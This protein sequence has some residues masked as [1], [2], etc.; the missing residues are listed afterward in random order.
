MAAPGWAGA[1][2]HRHHQR[3]QVC[4]DL[5]TRPGDGVLLHVPSYPPF[6]Q[7]LT[8]MQRELLALPMVRGAEGY[9]L[10]TEVLRDRAASRPPRR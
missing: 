10:D 9:G 7:T 1:R 2:V 6:L 3:A 4:L 5:G 8:R